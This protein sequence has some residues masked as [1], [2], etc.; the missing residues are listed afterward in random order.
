MAKLYITNINFINE[1][2]LVDLSDYRIN[3]SY[4]FKNKK[5]IL[6]SLAVGISLNKGL[7]EYN[8]KE[9]N[10]LIKETKFGKLFFENRKD[11]KFNLSHS[12]EI[13][14][15]VLSNKEIGCDIEKIRKYDKKIALKYFSKEENLF[16]NNSED[17][18]EAFTRIWILK[19]SFL[20]AIGIGLI[21]NM[22]EI[23]I[24]PSSN[25]IKIN[26]KIDRRNWKIEEK[27]IDDYFIAI[28]EEI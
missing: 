15:A 1:N 24:I 5:D 7:K 4:N 19:E 17:K 3:K 20:K 27:R 2:D 22:N 25:M 18:N 28:C 10:L 9:K 8:L 6:L 21:Q 11:I 12:G 13:G 26:Q 23:S 16:I 14:I